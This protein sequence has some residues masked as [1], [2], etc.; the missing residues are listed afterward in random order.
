MDD[1]EIRWNCIISKMVWQYSTPSN[2]IMKNKKD[3]LNYILKES[4]KLYT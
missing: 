3:F 1:T 2:N 4:A